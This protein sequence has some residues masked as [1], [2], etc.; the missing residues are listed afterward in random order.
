LERCKGK[1]DVSTLL[2]RVGDGSLWA[3]G[4]LVLLS[5]LRVAPGAPPGVVSE[6]DLVADDHLRHVVRWTGGVVERNHAFD[7]T[8]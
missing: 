7:L 2:Y 5:S 3:Y 8:G 1:K 6:R 4:R